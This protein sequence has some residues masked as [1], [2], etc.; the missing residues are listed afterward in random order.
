M[1]KTTEMLIYE[2]SLRVRLY[3][4]S[5]NRGKNVADLS[6][7]ETLL[8]E[9]IGAGEGMSI[10][11][12]AN[13]YPT[14]SNSTI[15]TT[16]TKL[17]RD[18]KLVEKTILP[19]N[20][21]KTMVSLTKAGRK[22]LNEIQQAQSITFRA[23]TEALGLTPEQNKYFQSVIENAIKFFDEKLGLKLDRLPKGQNQLSRP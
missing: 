7:R 17:W 10:S 4:A 13:L 12:I 16:I 6:D 15:S 11:E 5:Q 22:V 19:Q 23:I 21:R 2:M 1:G 14:V 8:L 20:Q 18:K 3:S 9:L